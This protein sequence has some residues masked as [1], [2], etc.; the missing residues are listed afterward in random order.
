M[1]RELNDDERGH[2][3]P[4]GAVDHGPINPK[5]D[6]ALGYRYHIVDRHTGNV[7]GKAKTLKH[8]SRSIDRRDNAYGAYRYTHRT[9]PET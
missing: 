1:E 8:A 3:G 5:S 7:V 6:Y 9:I 2:T 4:N